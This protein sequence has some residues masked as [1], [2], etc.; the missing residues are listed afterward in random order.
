MRTLAIAIVFGMLGTSHAAVL[1]AHQRDGTFNSTV[2]IREACKASET[3]VDPAS[4]GLVPG[5]LSCTHTRVPAPCDT[6]LIPDAVC[7]A[8]G[9][10]CASVFLSLLS[11][12]VEDVDYC[13]QPIRACSLGGNYVEDVECC[14]ITP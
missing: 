10:K 9:K 1:C 14:T 13:D 2:K 8:Q 6:T 5:N 4:L 7:S 11:V 3:A 12:G